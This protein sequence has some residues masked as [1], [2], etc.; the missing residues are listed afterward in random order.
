MGY[1]RKGSKM[2]HLLIVLLLILPL[3][4]KSTEP[5]SS[6][7]AAID[8][9]IPYVYGGYIVAYKYDCIGDIEVTRITASRGSFTTLGHH[10]CRKWTKIYFQEDHL[11]MRD[12]NKTIQ[13]REILK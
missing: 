1:I 4:C 13:K 5:V 12:Q 8:Y 11:F 10:Y 2:K 9:S 6:L 3:G 7:D